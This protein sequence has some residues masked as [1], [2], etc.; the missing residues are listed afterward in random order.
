MYAGT[1]VTPTARM[2]PDITFS[3]FEIGILG[4]PD[5]TVA[6]CT[7]RGF[8]VCTVFMVALFTTDIIFLLGFNRLFTSYD[9]SLML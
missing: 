8:R 9:L 7:I 3:G 1:A 5:M 2:T 4:G 6:L